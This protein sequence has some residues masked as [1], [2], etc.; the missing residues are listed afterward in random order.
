MAVI[1]LGIA[2]PPNHRPLSST[3]KEKG[4]QRSSRRPVTGN[5]H[6]RQFAR[7]D[8]SG[9]GYEL[10]LFDQN[11]QTRLR[12]N[13]LGSTRRRWLWDDFARV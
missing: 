7:L 9:A 13:D 4:T 11:G 1:V 10:H 6:Y 12:I 2:E 5:D 8:Q 3:A